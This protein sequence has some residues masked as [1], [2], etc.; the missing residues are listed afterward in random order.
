MKFD[1]ATQNQIKAA[2]PN[3]STWLSANAGSGKTR[4]LTDRVAR[5]LLG[6]VRPE[7]ILCLTYTKAA[8]T[9]MQNRLF[10]RLGH[11][12][13]MPDA[14]LRKALME[15]GIAA[16]D[17]PNDLS[18]P[19]T[20]FA[21][22]IET[23][24]GL[25]IQTIHS[26]CA[27][28]LRQ[29]PLEAGVSPQFKEIDERAQSL[30]MDQV[31]EKLCQ[32]HPE[33][34][35]SFFAAPGT[36]G[37]KDFIK[38]VLNI[39]ENLQSP[40]TYDQVMADHGFQPGT[41]AQSIMNDAFMPGDD[42]LITNMISDLPKFNKNQANGLKALP[43]GYGEDKFNALAKLW[44][45]AAPKNNPNRFVSKFGAPRG[46]PAK[47]FV[48]NCPYIADVEGFMTRIEVSKQRLLT[49]EVAQNTVALEQLGPLFLNTYAAAKEARGALD[50][51]DLITKTRQLLQKPGI[52]PWILYKL[53]GGIDH[54]LVDEAQDT[55]P[56]QW[57]IIELLT[58]EMTAGDGRDD[59]A[60]TLFVVGDMKQS[61][62]SF[63]GADPSEFGR[64]RTAFGERLGRIDKPLETA[65]LSHSFRSAHD[66]LKVVDAAFTQDH[67]LGE[68]SH[69]TAFHGDMPGRVDLWAFVEK[70]T[71]DKVDG[72]WED[73]VD[74][75]SPNHHDK[76][77]ADRLAEGIRDML[78]NG[79]LPTKNGTLRK[80]EPRDIMILM[81][82]RKGQVFGEIH[83]ALKGANLPVS[84]Y[85]RLTVTD[86]LAVRDL[87]VLL[88]F[89]VTPEDNLALA[90]A[91]KSPIFGWSEQDLFT[92]AAGDRPKILWTALRE[93]ESIFPQTVQT[94]HD[95]LAKPDFLR[96][97]E[98]LEYILINLDGRRKLLARLGAEA[99]EAIDAFL[100]LALD[101]EQNETPSLT[102][103]LVWLSQ[104]DIE[105][106]RQL[107]GT[108]NEIRVMTV[109]G[110]K[111][112]EAP[113]VILPKLGPRD[114]PKVDR[115]TVDEQGLPI[116]LNPADAL[117]NHLRP[118]CE[119]QIQADMEERDRQ[120][121]VALT[122]AET[123][124][125]LAGSG[126][127]SV[128]TEKDK[129]Y[130]YKTLK[131][132]LTDLGAVEIDTP[133]GRGLRYQTID[134]PTQMETA[135]HDGPPIGAIHPVP[136]DTITAPTA[137]PKRINPSNQPGAKAVPFEP[138]GDLDVLDYGAA[139]HALL[140]VLPNHP[141]QD[142]DTIAQNMAADDGLAE[143]VSVL[144]HPDLKFVFDQGALAEVP[145]MGHFG[146]DA[147]ISGSI[148]RLIIGDETVLIVDFKTNRA[149]PD[150]VQDMPLGILHQM[151]AYTWA[152]E[153]VFP[154][155]TVQ[156][157]V[158][159]TKT[160]TLMAIPPQ[161]LLPLR[162]GLTAS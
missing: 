92:L 44:L 125:I 65:N 135:A 26:F 138:D 152:M 96:P 116:W 71:D 90:S 25:K 110:A 102:G 32:D 67:G 56:E 80:I 127:T 111:G 2:N 91:L 123:W 27:S 157:A 103:F 142:W 55:S 98:L 155:K 58:E 4:V 60:R 160:C 159:W 108:H 6:G 54:I 31:L 89:L 75:L 39:A 86:E 18:K 40:R 147:P 150:T 19:R 105:V 83:R 137:A 130:P 146:A 46:W 140:E 49:W 120:L 114:A 52:A 139:V 48:E 95:L 47:K 33:A 11:W 24:G 129:V 85:D 151:A 62:Y 29:F 76:V 106:K 34:L 57:Q 74:Q 69:H 118:I 149:V 141:A 23:P 5:L 66:V 13:M 119:A 133:T 93:K 134:W 161:M 158:L 12:T 20:L 87:H 154:G 22:A 99:E 124:L 45:T 100:S 3:A 132:T 81:H 79:H 17:Q 36:G 94:L 70:S 148:D 113:I 156:S 126:D 9:E 53:D 38:G 109:H 64:M 21:T 51:N 112:L 153:R 104:S 84:G 50:F 121:Y 145:V 162:S 136:P 144:T 82:S 128:S 15:L 63:Q 16:N 8:A 37:I 59:R 73:P 131:K 107:D 117:P 10:K 97:Y 61:I 28:I 78:D 77:L 101:Y 43:E 72:N 30:L 35:T 122:R 14:D 42:D 41:T 68:G 115:I 88:E 7:N 143:A 1:D